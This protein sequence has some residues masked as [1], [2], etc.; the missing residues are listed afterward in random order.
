VL[1]DDRHYFPPYECAI[2]VREQ[3][4][5]QYAGLQSALQELS[6]RITAETMRRLNYELDGKHRPA[7]EIA[8]DFL[9]SA[10]LE[11]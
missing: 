8:K 5:Q 4:L 2:I 7:R 11:H 1:T 6:G 9:R 3:A 10:G